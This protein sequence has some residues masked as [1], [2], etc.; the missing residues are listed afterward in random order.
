MPYLSFSH[1]TREFENQ[2][3][4]RQRLGCRVAP[5]NDGINSL[6]ERTTMH[7]ASYAKTILG[8]QGTGLSGDTNSG[9]KKTAGPGP[10]TGWNRRL[11]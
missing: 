3:L 2:C 6:R 11:N 1:S 7:P 8:T 9:Q 4:S 10:V 5:G